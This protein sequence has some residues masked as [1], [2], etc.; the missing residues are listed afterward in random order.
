MLSVATSLLA[1]TALAQTAATMRGDGMKTD[2]LGNVYS[3]S[4]AGP[5]IVRITAPDAALPGFLNLPIYGGEPK[6]QICATNV[7]FGDSDFKSLYI[8]AC[9]VVYR[10]RLAVA[11]S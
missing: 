10:I 11:G 8:T 2:L 9:D 6:R 1:A 4:G 5:G 7:A 3:T